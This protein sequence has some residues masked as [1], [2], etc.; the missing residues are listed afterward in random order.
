[1]EKYIIKTP[2]IFGH[3]IDF[4][5]NVCGSERN[6]FWLSG[7]LECQDLAPFKILSHVKQCMYIQEI[8]GSS[9]RCYDNW[10]NDKIPNDI[11]PSGKRMTMSKT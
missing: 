6:C 1:M 11:L 8:S 3:K 9:K 7:L 4:W 5:K 2:K 10:P